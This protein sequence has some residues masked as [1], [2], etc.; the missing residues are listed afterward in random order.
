MPLEE[1]A[2]GV[3]QLQSKDG[4]PVRLVVQPWA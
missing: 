3:E 4:D 1:V 2:A